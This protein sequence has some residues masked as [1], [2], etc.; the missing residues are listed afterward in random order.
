[1]PSLGFLPLWVPFSFILSA[2]SFGISLLVFLLSQKGKVNIYCRGEMALFLKLLPKRFSFFWET[3][4][5]PDSV[6]R[7]KKVFSK[8]RGLIVVTKYYAEELVTKF[9]VGKEKVFYF[10][11]AVDLSLFKNI[12]LSKEQLRKQLSL[13]QDKTIIS[14]AGKFKTMGQT[15]GVEN[16]LIS[17]KNLSKKY[18]GIYLLLVGL[19]TVETPNIKK[20]LGDCRAYQLVEYVP[21]GQLAKYELASDILVMNY[22]DSFHYRYYMSPLKMFEYMATN[23]P[24]V[25][26]DLPCIRDVLSEK[27]AVLFAPNDLNNLTDSLERLIKDKDL[28]RRLSEQALSDVSEYTWD[29]RAKEI[30]NFMNSR[31]WKK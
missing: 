16:I 3:H 20:L 19:E 13:P 12:N 9:K 8:S 30:L 29:K 24:I 31:L 18:P 27:N 17:F 4:I 6:N 5:K 14:Y 7:Y 11:D 28:S 25:T 15:K 26:T 1:M 2:A 23:N 10:P 22:P 21:M